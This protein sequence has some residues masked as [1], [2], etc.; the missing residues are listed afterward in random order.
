[1]LVGVGLNLA[2]HAPQELHEHDAV[3]AENYQ[4]LGALCPEV[5]LQMA[6]AKVIAALEV[7][8]NTWCLKGMGP[9]LELFDQAHALLGAQVRAHNGDGRDMVG[10]VTGIAADGGLTLQCDGEPVTIYAGEVT[11]VRAL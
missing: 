10:W 7:A 8:Y 3:A 11:R 6:Q 4:G 2:P 1:M 9:T 5:T